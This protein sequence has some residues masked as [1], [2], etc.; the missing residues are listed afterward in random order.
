[1][2][3]KLY[4]YQII[5]S[6]NMYEKPIIITFDDGYLDT[7]TK[8]FPILQKYKLKATVFIIANWM[9][10]DRYMSPEQIKELDSSKIFEIG[11]HTLSH[12]FLS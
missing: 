8:A 11:S 3:I 1:M 10:G 9:D 6:A 12:S 4:I 2:I 5:E 7:Y